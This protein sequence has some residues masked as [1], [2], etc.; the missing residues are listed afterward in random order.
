MP[1]LSNM[2]WCRMAH[3]VGRGEGLSKSRFIRERLFVWCVWGGGAR[4]GCVCVC[5]TK[6]R[7]TNLSQDFFHDC[8]VVFL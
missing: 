7:R 2:R 5:K 1:T 8:R 3:I 4:G 6:L